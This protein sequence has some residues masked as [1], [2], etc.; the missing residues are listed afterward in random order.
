MH[1]CHDLCCNGKVSGCCESLSI[2]E[3]II[4]IECGA[5]NAGVR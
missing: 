3:F 2:T 4:I 1:L 5:V